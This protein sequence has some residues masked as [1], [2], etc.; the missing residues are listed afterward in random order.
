MP[1]YCINHSNRKVFSH[2]RCIECYRREILYPKSLLKEKKTYKIKPYSNKRE[3]LN[4]VYTIKKKE[5]CAQLVA[6]GKNVCYFT[7]VKLDPDI[8]P[9]FHHS[10]GKDGDLLTDMFYAF[11]ATFKAHREY[12]D[13][14]YDYDHL[15]KVSWYKDF[16][17]RLKKNH[18]LLYEKERYKIDRAN[19]KVTRWQSM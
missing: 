4:L 7:N 11:P 15:E 8:L 2:N 14:K 18:P 12:H 10:I 3:I 5:K 13:L 16:L 19:K 9:A 17:E 1:K 6:E